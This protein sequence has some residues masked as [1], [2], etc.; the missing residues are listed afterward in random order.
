M[1]AFQSLLGTIQSF[2]AESVFQTD[3]SHRTPALALD[4]DFAF[5]VLITT[6]LV[7][8]EINNTNARINTLST[9]INADVAVK[10]Q[11]QSDLNDKLSDLSCEKQKLND[12][13]G[14][15][16]EYMSRFE[17]SD[18]LQDIKLR[19]DGL[20]NEIE[21][22]KQLKLQLAYLSKDLGNISYE[23]AAQKLALIQN[24]ENINTADIENGK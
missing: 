16:N 20:K 22:Q 19:I 11:R 17:N 2:V 13:L 15:I 4:E 1:F 18:T 12:A 3:T 14:E 8:E 5:L 23:D 10:A 21:K 24:G 6:N 9:I 7:A